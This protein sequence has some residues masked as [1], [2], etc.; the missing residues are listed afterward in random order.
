ME[1]ASDTTARIVKTIDEI[2]FQTNLL[3]L[4]AAVAAARAGDAGR[5]F[6]VVADEVRNLAI[7]SAAATKNTSALIEQSCNSGHGGGESPGVAG[8]AKGRRLEQALGPFLV[9]S[10]TTRA[11][12][13]D[14]PPSAVG[15]ISV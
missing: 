6:A 10:R 11:C 9:C 7:R 12:T 3:A 4:N 14:I 15:P 2:A 8:A 1:R 13:S 5:G